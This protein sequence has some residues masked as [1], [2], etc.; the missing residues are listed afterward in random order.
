MKLVWVPS[1]QEM[2]GNEKA[3]D[4]TKTALEKISKPNKDLVKMSQNKQIGIKEE[5]SMNRN[6]LKQ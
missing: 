5:L 6:Q 1:Y 4:L 3:N 2:D